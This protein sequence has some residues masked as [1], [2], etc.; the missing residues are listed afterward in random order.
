MKI[1]IFIFFF[2][3]LS[4]CL[5]SCDSVPAAHSFKMTKNRTPTEG[6]K[7]N[8]DLKNPKLSST[9]YE[10]ALSPDPDQFAQKHNILLDRRRVRV[11]IYFEPSSPEPE[12]ISILKAHNVMIEK[13]SAGMLRV[14]APV[15][16][17]IPLS[18][19]PSVR[20][21]RLPETLIKTRKIHP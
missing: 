17:L 16:Q 12:R 5:I 4:G 8:G 2:I 14:L 13:R 21:I 3:F 9:L 10:L 18:E 7:N 1:R 20:L 19:D 11:Y 15:D 6:P